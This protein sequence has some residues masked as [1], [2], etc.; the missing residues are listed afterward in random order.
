MV[1]C[2]QDGPGPSV[3]PPDP[4]ELGSDPRRGVRAIAAVA[5][6]LWLLALAGG[7]ALGGL[8]V[9]AGVSLGGALALA[10][11]WMLERSVLRLLT[12]AGQDDRRGAAW[13]VVRWVAI[14]VT[15]M[16]ALWA[17]DVDPLGL[18]VGLTVVVTAILVTAGVGLVRG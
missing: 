1:V 12:S 6:A 18:L 11:L 17:F 14:G 16:V 2:D 8:D 4:V 7:Y 15:L 3:P 9:A 10:N 13:T 5:G